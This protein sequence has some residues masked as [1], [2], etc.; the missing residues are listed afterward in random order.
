MQQLLSCRI[1]EAQS[2]T[3]PN[4]QVKTQFIQAKKKKNPCGDLNGKEAYHLK[5]TVSDIP[6][7]FI[8][9]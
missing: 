2:T 8:E 6:E 5:L 9:G 4:I 1:G 7:A 3:R